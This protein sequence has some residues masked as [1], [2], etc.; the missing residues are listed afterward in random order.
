MDEETSVGTFVG[1]IITDA[2]LVDVF[3]SVDVSVLRFSFLR[4]GVTRFSLDRVT[5]VL[6]TSGRLDREA[7][8]DPS[9]SSSSSSSTCLLRM[10]V[11]V[12]PMQFF[13]VVR[14]LVY[15]RD[16]NDNAPQSV[17]DHL[18]ADV[19][20][21]ES[22][23]Y[24]KSYQIKSNQIKSSVDLVRLQQLE[25]CRLGLSNLFIYDTLLYLIFISKC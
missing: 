6:T 24:I 25:R 5:G 20:V 7:L 9:S 1:N 23:Q 22:N 10:D 17:Y 15:V 16:I 19:T 8:C 12:Q 21:L 3:P 4:R 2:R 18:I 11:A 14:V 13:R